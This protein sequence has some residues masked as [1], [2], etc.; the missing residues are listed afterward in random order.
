MIA[1]NDRVIIRIGFRDRVGTVT[2]I[3]A[4]GQVTVVTD[5]GDCRTLPADQVRPAVAQPEP[6]DGGA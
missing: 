5:S 2:A 3:R 6:Y 1:V 4:R